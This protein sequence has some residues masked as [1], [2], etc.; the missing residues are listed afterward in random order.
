MR[1][2]TILFALSLAASAQNAPAAKVKAQP[3]APAAPRAYEFPKAA[4]KT[5][6]N[7]LKVFVVEDHRLPLVSAS[8]EVLA[9]NAYV[10]PAKSGLASTTAGLLREGTATRSS[11]QLAKAIDTAGGS[12]STSAGDDTASVSMTFMKS[13][14]GLGFELMA[15]ITLNPAFA[16]E[17]ID[18]Q[19]RQAQ[20]GLAV[21]YADAE[22]LAP[23]A[24]ARAMLGMHPYAFPGSG[25]PATLASI[26]RDDIVAFYK[27]NYAPN[28]AWMAI[29][30]DVTPAEGFALAEKYFGGWKAAGRPDEKLPEPPAPKAQVLILDMPNAVQTQIVVGHVGVPRNHP[31]YL[32]LLLGNQ[33]FGGS[34]NSRLNMKLRANEGLTYGANSGFEPN[35]FAGLFQAS[36]FTRTEKTAAAI[37]M[38]V[39]LL[40]EFKQNPATETEFR[41]AQAYM[42]GVFG[43]QTE[44]AGAVAGRVLS[45]EING[46]GADYWQTYRQRVQA[47]TREQAAAAIQRFLQP[48][49]L[50]II[51]VGN[52]KE[53]AKD[54]EK[55][56]PTR[57]IK[58]DEVDF[59][60]PGLL[61]EKPKVTASP[62]GGAKAKALVSKALEAMGGR[63]KLAALK[64]V[65]T[66]GKLKLTMPQGSFDADTTEEV[67]YPDRFK[68]VM[69]LPMGVITQAYASGEAWMGQGT[70][71]RDLPPN[72][73]PELAKSVPA[74]SGGIG[75]LL[76]AAEGK[77]E[78]QLVDDTT[79]LWKSPAFEATLG[80]DA[81]TG[82][83]VKLTMKTLGMTGPAEV[84]TSFDD[85]R[86]EGGLTLPYKESMAQNGQ[87]VGVRTIT[88]R[89]VNS[90]LKPESFGK[91]K[92]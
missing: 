5:L 20:S 19:M 8:L 76:A 6:A 52:A 62:E 27:A 25:T 2:L 17:E 80:F 33:I 3:P 51:A 82:R 81:A 90:G 56:G 30:G 44:T 36:T 59:T 7:G 66:V 13:F 46:L 48:D 73:A 87:T 50:S 88:E 83:L 72:M 34:F 14:A 54:L 22:Y 45:A 61:K 85:F 69:K 49:K 70:M 26:K 58:S 86:A 65:T 68:M 74:A 35:R 75:L 24:G 39:D 40:K 77:A 38:L 12:L 23:L 42:S 11:Q 53:F 60:A 15:D 4:S 92:Q 79:V 32:A 47:L 37:G 64:D 43:I 18:R 91:P 84:V 71:V 1:T 89:K 16:Q 31:D 55:F 57:V 29:A 21:Q 78:A 28:R 10:E 9:G 63:E 41:E 67:L